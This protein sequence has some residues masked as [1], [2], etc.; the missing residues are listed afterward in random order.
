MLAIFLAAVAAY[1]A[2]AVQSAVPVASRESRY[3]TSIS[4]THA[5]IV[6]EEEL[7]NREVVLRTFATH[8]QET[9]S[10]ANLINFLSSIS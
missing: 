5:I 4:A 7:Q 9:I 6:G 8:S 10:E 2:S 3:A 1:V